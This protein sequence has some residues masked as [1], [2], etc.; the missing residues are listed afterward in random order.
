MKVRCREGHVWR[1]N[2]TVDGG[3]YL[4]RP[5]EVRHVS[6]AELEQLAGPLKGLRYGKRALVRADYVEVKG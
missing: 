5:G 4:T 1:V 3:V 6:R 2:E